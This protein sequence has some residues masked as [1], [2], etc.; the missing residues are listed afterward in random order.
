M[1]WFTVKEIAEG[2]LEEIIEHQK[3]KS[4][5]AVSLRPLGG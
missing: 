2:D 1:G 5:K 3:K 4:R